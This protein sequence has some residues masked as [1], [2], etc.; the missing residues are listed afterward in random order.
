[1]SKLT[2]DSE[3][4]KLIK[5]L[6]NRSN[7]EYD[8]GKYLESIE[9]LEDAWY[10]LPEPKG[11]YSESYYIASDISEIYLKL[12][13]LK[14]AKK[15]SDELFKCALH[16]IDSGEREFLAGKV[17][18]ESSEFDTAKQYFTI[19][20]EKS[21]GRCFEDEPKKYIQFLKKDDINN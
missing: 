8:Q 5:S 10:R 4:S 11:G 17:A 3:L 14:E 16:R 12:K 18:F 20:N 2:L 19:A 1:M 6:I 15:W 13:K 21:E 7:E 9:I